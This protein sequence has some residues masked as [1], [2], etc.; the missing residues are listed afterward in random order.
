MLDGL[1]RGTH[2][3]GWA[4]VAF[5]LLAAVAPMATGTAVMMI[6]GLALLAAAALLGWFGMRAREVGI[7][8][9][10]LIVAAV[11]A[12][13]GLVLLFNPSTGMA[14]VR[15]L[16]IVYFLLSGV[17]EILTAWAL[18]GDEGWGWMLGAGVVSVL[19]STALWTNW[20]ISGAHAIGLL[21]GANLASVGWAVVQVARRMDAAGQRLATVRARLR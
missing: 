3:V 14:V 5:G 13:V 4:L 21:V 16:L 17:S 8:P 9:T 20:P 10:P 7:G 19:A 11:A 12:L 1:I 18:R 6:V 2:H 15:F